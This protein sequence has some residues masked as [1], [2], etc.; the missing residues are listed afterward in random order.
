MGKGSGDRRHDGR[1]VER[2]RQGGGGQMGVGWSLPCPGKWKGGEKPSHKESGVGWGEVSVRCGV[3]WGEA[4]GEAN[5]IYYHRM[6]HLPYP[7]PVIAWSSERGESP[8][9]SSCLPSPSPFPWDACLLLP[10][11]LRFCPP[12][13]KQTPNV[14]EWKKGMEKGGKKEWQETWSFFKARQSLTRE[15]GQGCLYRRETAMAR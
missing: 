14:P 2:Q 12:S 11:C 13:A 5:V 9:S 4:W 3:R 10:A 7:P 15:R 1:V 8:S 6:G